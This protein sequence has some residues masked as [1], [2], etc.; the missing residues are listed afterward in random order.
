MNNYNDMR[1]LLKTEIRNFFNSYNK[2]L[3]NGEPFH[4]KKATLERMEN[5]LYFIVSGGGFH[6]QSLQFKKIKRKEE[7][8]WNTS[9]SKKAKPQLEWNFIVEIYYS[10]IFSGIIDLNKEER[11]LVVKVLKEK[12]KGFENTVFYYL[13]ILGQELAQYI[14]YKEQIEKKAEMIKIFNMAHQKIFTLYHQ[15]LIQIPRTNLKDVSPVTFEYCEEVRRYRAL[16]DLKKLILKDLECTP[17]QF[18]EGIKMGCYH[19]K[20]IR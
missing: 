12:N 9:N 20:Y 3:H 4:K 11:E 5:K 1:E 10:M 16:T 6:L 13:N 15:A 14:W 17:E 7:D 8:Y 2:L 19:Y 18:I